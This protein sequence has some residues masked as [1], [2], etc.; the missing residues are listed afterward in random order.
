M[1]EE[2]RASGHPALERGLRI[3]RLFRAD[4]PTFTVKAIA[5]RLEIPI[6][7]SYRLVNTLLALGYLEPAAAGAGSVQLGLE[8][9]RMMSLASAQTDILSASSEALRQLASSTKETALIAVPGEAKAICIGLVEG[10]SPIRPR[11]ARVGE[12]LPYNGGAI[13]L[14]ILAFSDAEFRHRILG[15]GLQRYTDVTPVDPSSIE[16]ICAK[17]RAKGHGYSEG[18]YIEGTAAVAAPIFDA[19]GRI[20][21]AVGITGITQNMVNKEQAVRDAA[22]SVT[23]RLGGQPM[24]SLQLHEVGESG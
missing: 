16:E 23:L 5:A 6:A 17:V 7:T 19:Q 21:G 18:D 15:T 24:I 1:T 4:E 13:A 22:D 20:A 14:T 9:L 3:L 11:S 12:S 8:T 10:T 2:A